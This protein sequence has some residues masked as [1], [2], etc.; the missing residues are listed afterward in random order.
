MGLVQL[1][2]GWEFRVKAIGPACPS[3]AWSWNSVRIG[4]VEPKTF[5]ILRK[6]ALQQSSTHED[7]Y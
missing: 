4:T 2:G 1:E 6:K 7:S 5:V 3:P